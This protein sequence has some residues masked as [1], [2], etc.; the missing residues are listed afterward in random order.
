VASLALELPPPST[1]LRSLPKSGLIRTLNLWSMGGTHLARLFLASAARTGTN[2]CVSCSSPSATLSAVTSLLR[3]FFPGTVRSSASVSDRA[4]IF[5]FFSACAF[6]FFAGARVA[7]TARSLSE[8]PSWSAVV[9]FLTLALRTRVS[10]EERC[11]K[12][13]L[14]SG[15]WFCVNFQS[16]GFR[17]Q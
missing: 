15:V 7:V 2:D 4:T 5:R 1:E 3:F 16:I 8:P 6:C 13:V 10:N 9:L 17:Y 11:L 14:S 12:I